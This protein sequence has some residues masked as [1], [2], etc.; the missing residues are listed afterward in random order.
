[1]QTIF[2]EVIVTNELPRIGSGYRYIRA[3]IGNKWVHVTDL[4][5]ENRSKLSM[6]VWDG[7]K[8]GRI[9]NADDAL[10]SLRKA[11]RMMNRQPRRKL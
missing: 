8:K 4:D 3:S 10:K 7:I 6:K 9:I 11:D 2:Q 5:G 1:M